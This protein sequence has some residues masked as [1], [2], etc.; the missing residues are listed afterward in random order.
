MKHRDRTD[1][2]QRDAVLHRELREE[3]DLKRTLARAEA[4]RD[5]E[6]LDGRSTLA[7]EELDRLGFRADVRRPSP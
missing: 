1:A 6:P 7:Q 2:V 5:F 3:L 4:R